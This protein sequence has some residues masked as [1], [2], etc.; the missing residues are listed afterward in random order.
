LVTPGHSGAWTLNCSMVSMLDP[1]SRDRK[2]E[3]ISLQRRVCE[4]SVPS[5]TPSFSKPVR[6]WR[7]R[8]ASGP[9]TAPPGHRPAP[10]A[11]I[12]HESREPNAYASNE[13]LLILQSFCHW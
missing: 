11:P 1:P 7:A 3:S 9:A 5:E 12:T 6:H 10:S 4:L 2:L 13:V 8:C